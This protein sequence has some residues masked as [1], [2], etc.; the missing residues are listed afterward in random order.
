MKSLNKW[1][2]AF[3]AEHQL[4]HLQP[5]D[6]RDGQEPSPPWTPDNLSALTAALVSAHEASLDSC[7]LDERRL[8]HQS[9]TR[10]SSAP[11]L[12]GLAATQQPTP[13]LGLSQCQLGTP[14]RPQR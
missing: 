12:P 6:L 7:D 10:A 4:S 9:S 2:D 3:L 13:G 11:V 5:P 14:Q 1:L 8:L